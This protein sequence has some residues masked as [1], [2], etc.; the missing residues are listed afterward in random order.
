M[1][2]TPPTIAFAGSTYTY[3]VEATG[4]PAA[5]YALLN[6]PS[7][8]PAGM[9][10]DAATGLI[11]WTPTAASTYTVTVQAS[12]SEGAVVQSFA[13]IVL[14]ANILSFRDVTK[15]SDTGGPNWFGGHGVQFADVTGDGCPD[16]Y[17]TM[18]KQPTDMGE[19]FYRNVDGI[20]F[21]EEAAIRGILDFDTGSHGGVWA[22]F[23]NDGDFDLLNG[24]YERN[25]LYR[26]EGDGN[27]GDL[28][29]GSGLVDMN[30]GTRAVVA[31]D[32]DGDGDLDLFCNNWMDGERNEFYLNNGAKNFVR[33]D[34]GLQTYHGAQGATEA[35]FDNDGDIDL[36]IGTWSGN[37]GLMR[38][39]GLGFFTNVAESV[40]LPNP[41]RI[42]GA[43]W[44]DVNNDGWLDLHFN[45]TIYL[46]QQG[47]SFAP[48]S[49]P[50]GPGFM[51]GF[52]DLDN[53]GDWD[54]VYPGDNKVYLND[55]SGK[56]IASPPFSIGT[57]KDPRGVAFSDLDNDGDVDFFYAQ[58]QT[59]NILIRN[60]YNG[61]N[62]WLKVKLFRQNGQAGAFGSRVY[63]YETGHVGEENYRIT[64]REARSQ[65]GYLCQNDPVLHFG[66]G[67]S[68]AVDVRVIFPSGVVV[69]EVSV[70]SNQTIR[71]AET[72][73]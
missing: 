60:D 47:A 18:N 68:N 46:N 49:A 65:E 54:L 44:V 41:N 61:S 39:N 19:L 53:D 12:N 28:T 6:N 31:F 11:K 59:Y 38:N 2:S 67:S 56:F 27:F 69:N 34:R 63:V 20:A 45:D 62:N 16:F 70:G 26:N 40:G 8:A 33:V 48:I 3:D 51:A 66:V 64:W 71:I 1:V 17:V 5:S 24:S 37:R 52:E 43:T 25:R 21:V 55:G 13:I 15:I 50:A 14:A 7:P 57:V 35:D 36:F 30:Y 32:A 23:D 4:Y 73:R 58:K 72:A 42:D 10:M 9:T 29:G 22:D